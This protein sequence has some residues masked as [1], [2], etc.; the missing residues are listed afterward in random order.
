LTGNS[1]ASHASIPTAFVGDIRESEMNFVK[2]PCWG[3]TITAPDFLEQHWPYDLPPEAW[4]TFL[5]AGS[6]WGDTIV[7]DSFG[8]AYLNP[9]GLCHDVEW[10]CSAKTPRAFLAA[11]GRFFLNCA[12][13]ILA[14][15]LDVWPKIKVLTAVSGVYLAAVS[16]AGVLFFAWFSGDRK[17]DPYP[18]Q[19]PTVHHRLG[20][21]AEAR[22]KY[23]E[24]PDERFQDREDVLY[25]ADEKGENQ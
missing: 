25:R 13:L 6:G 24:K 18:M 5:G 15:D 11:N 20:R 1:N 16:T 17:E 14:A 2:I 3:A 4:P 8:K 9:A 10:A 19:N 7:P 23:Y 12:S 22:K 21:L